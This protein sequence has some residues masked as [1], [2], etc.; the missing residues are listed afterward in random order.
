MGATWIGKGK[1]CL[2]VVS[3]FGKEILIHNN[4]RHICN[5]CSTSAHCRAKGDEKREI[6]KSMIL[7]DTECIVLMESQILTKSNNGI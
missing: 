3:T 2:H 7:S 5:S 6:V 4:R 1:N